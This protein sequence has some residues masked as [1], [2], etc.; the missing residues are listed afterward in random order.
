MCFIRVK[1]AGHCTASGWSL[2]TPSWHRT[3]PGRASA[4]DIIYRC[5]PPPVQYVTTQE[6][7]LKNRP[8]PGRLSNSPVMCKSLKSYVVSFICDHS[9]ICVP[10]LTMQTSVV[11][12]Q[13][14]ERS[15]CMLI[16]YDFLIALFLFN[17]SLFYTQLFLRFLIWMFVSLCTTMV[18]TGKWLCYMHVIA[19]I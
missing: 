9:I 16:L 6:K 3:V 15:P 7:F 2:T 8:M 5:R 14:L 4:D 12:A 11:V 19:I 18:N 1:S 13:W 17:I 10:I